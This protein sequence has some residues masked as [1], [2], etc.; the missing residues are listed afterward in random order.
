MSEPQ[1]VSELAEEA[2]GLSIIDGVQYDLEALADQGLTA[3][4]IKK[5]VALKRAQE[6]YDTLIEK[7]REERLAL[8]KKFVPLRESYYNQRSDILVNG[9]LDTNTSD[10]PEATSEGDKKDDDDDD[11]MPEFWLRAFLNHESLE[12]LITEDDYNLFMA[13][14]DIRVECGDDMRS[15]KLIFIMS[16][17]EYIENETLTKEYRGLDLLGDEST[18][19]EIIG[20]SIKWKEGKNLLFKEVKKKQRAKSGKKAGETRIVT[21][22]QGVKS[23]FHYFTE[24]LPPEEELGED[25]VDE[26]AELRNIKFDYDSDYEAGHIIRTEIIPNAINWYT[27]EAIDEEEDEDE[28]DEDDDDADDEDEDDEDEGDD[29]VDKEELDGDFG[30]EGDDGDEVRGPAQVSGGKTADGEE[31]GPECKNS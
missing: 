21:R 25:E 2:A 8:E 12:S 3:G 4:V 9:V 16:E 26:Y 15:F 11:A 23:F 28:G 19:E 24:P 31:K 17:N 20:C 10:Q 22:K 13:I 6:G 1:S 27:G 14:K 29:D 7:Y 5:I 18:L 30:D